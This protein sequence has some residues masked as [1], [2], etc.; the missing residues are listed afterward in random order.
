MQ[1]CLLVHSDSPNREQTPYSLLCCPQSNV[2]VVKLLH[3]VYP[4][5]PLFPGTNRKSTFP[6]ASLCCLTHFLFV[7]NKTI[8]F[9]ALSPPAGHRAVVILDS[10][11]LCTDCL[12]VSSL[13]IKHLKTSESLGHVCSQHECCSQGTG[14]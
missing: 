9:V 8:D 2:E 14:T 11:R 10:L 5:D 7:K 12:Y 4:L 6:G 3:F 1:L 13:H